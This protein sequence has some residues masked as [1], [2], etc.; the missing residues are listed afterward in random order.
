LEDTKWADAAWLRLANAKVG[1]IDLNEAWP[2]HLELDGLTYRS[3]DNPQSH[4]A[5]FARLGGFAAQPYD[6]LAS[7]VHGAGDDDLATTIRYQGR[8]RERHEESSW[9][10]W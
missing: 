1:Y 9:I 10:S 8:Q 6:Q 3:V 2:A 4:A 5:W 7:V